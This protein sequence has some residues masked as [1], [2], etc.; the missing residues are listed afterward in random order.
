VLLQGFMSRRRLFT[1]ALR[2][3]Q[4]FR[5]L[6]PGVLRAYVPRARANLPAVGTDQERQ[7]ILVQGCV[8][9]GLSPTTNQAATLV[10]DRLGIGTVVV[11]AETCCGA[12]SYHLNGQQRGLEQ[13][14]AN[15][16]AWWP[17]L[18]AGAEAIVM[19]ASGC[20][21]FVQDYA[22]LL[23][24]DPDYADRAQQVSERLKDISELLVGEDLESLQ[25]ME[26]PTLGWHC[27]CTAQHGQKFD[28]PTREVM[29]RLGFE[30]ST[31]KDAHLC[32][33]SA[34]TYSLFEPELSKELRRRKLKELEADSPQQI[35]T[36]NIGC[37]THLSGGTDTPVVHWIE[38]LARALGPK[39]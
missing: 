37:Q 2:L 33:G 21:N 14:K 12:L 5:F 34:G 13:A 3:G 20:S 36:A 7:V 30:L 17:H 25:V 6:L 10:L 39:L 38:L 1:P 22:A 11:S 32:C 18:E 27:P 8:Q 4:W 24:A 31:P 35:V 15:I 29:G 28:G 19:T 9:P 16:D 23:G 26:R